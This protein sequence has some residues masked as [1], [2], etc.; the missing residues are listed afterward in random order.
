MPT[1]AELDISGMGLAAIDLSPMPAMRRLFLQGNRL[2]ALDAS[3]CPQLE[4]VDCS[5]N[6]LTARDGNTYSSV[7]TLDAQAGMVTVSGT[8]V[9]K[10]EGMGD[11]YI[12]DGL[13]FKR[14]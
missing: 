13:V 10:D 12:S 4:W 3:P 7:L 9:L 2:T 5:M 8:R 6:A 1:L 11:C 14:Q